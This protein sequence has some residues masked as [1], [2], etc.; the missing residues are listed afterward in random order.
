MKKVIHS[1]ILAIAV[2]ACCFGQQSV[3]IGLVVSPILS[4][5][6]SEDASF[7][8]ENRFSINYGGQISYNINKLRVNTGIS[9]L[10]Q[11]GNIKVLETSTTN[12]SGTGSYLSVP[13]V[14]KSIVIP[15]TLSYKI[16]SKNKTQLFVGTG[17]A[18]GYLF[19]QYLDNSAFETP[20][21]RTITTNGITYTISGVGIPKY[22]ELETFDK[23]YSHITLSAELH[24]TFNKGWNG[25]VRPNFNQQIRSKNATQSTWRQSYWGLD[26][27]IM[28]QIK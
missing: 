9:Y 10:K 12:P 25:F 1:I 7:D 6:A 14:T 17:F 21:V 22:T 18:L 28:R 4:K 24:R 3:E 15:A 19:A 20:Q 5:I 27:G 8:T 11:G 2:N 26:V 23:F 16:L 13:C